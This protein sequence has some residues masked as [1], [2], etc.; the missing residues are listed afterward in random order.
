[1]G[2]TVASDGG[3]D[4]RL[5][6]YAAARFSGLLRVDGQPGGAIH[7]V[8][9]GI[10]ACETSGAPSLEVLLL[11]S[12]RVAESDWSAAFAQA[13]IA[14]R[15]MTAELVERGLLGAGEVEAL[16]RV[17]LADALFALTSGRVD[18]VTETP[19]A[20]CLLPLDPAAR[21]G[22]LLAEAARRR[23]VLASFPA[24]LLSASDRITVAH[25]TALPHRVLGPGQDE[26]LA[27][28]DGRR[29]PRDLAFALGRG[30]YVTM[31]EL[32]RMRAGSTVVISARGQ[33]TAPPTSG[34]KELD[35]RDE[36]ASGLPRRGRD[37]TGSSRAGETG[38]RGFAANLRMLL[39]RSEGDSPVETC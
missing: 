31:L 4:G 22:W 20:E 12:G 32:A 9:G 29:T 3:L 13:A 19:A 28:V 23:Q 16:L 15:P 7:F 26:I 34:E 14:D 21:A 25:G 10:S 24:P 6:D 35:A 30:L 27:L 38:R 17:A 1:M 33:A 39:P 8:E 2:A 37:R 36:T 18:N 11:R 5:R